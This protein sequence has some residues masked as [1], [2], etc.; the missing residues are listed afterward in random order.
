MKTLYKMY[1]SALVA[2]IFGIAAFTAQAAIA[3]QTSL[4]PNIPPDCLT[5]PTYVKN[6]CDL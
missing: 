1:P 3:K 4:L 5:Y 2:V 6:I